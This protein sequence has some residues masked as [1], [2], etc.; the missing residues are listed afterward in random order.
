MSQG[1]ALDL[2]FSLR[3]RLQPRQAWTIPARAG[4]V[5]VAFVGVLEP[6]RSLGCESPRFLSRTL[7][8]DTLGGVAYGEGAEFID[9]AAGGSGADAGIPGVAVRVDRAH[10]ELISTG[11]IDSQ[12]ADQQRHPLALVPLPRRLVSG[13]RDFDGAVGLG[14]AGVALGSSCRCLRRPCI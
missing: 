14:H 6:T 1:G 5:G 8:L 7:G 10:P 4:A 12:F 9:L 13:V 11:F 2:G 3:V